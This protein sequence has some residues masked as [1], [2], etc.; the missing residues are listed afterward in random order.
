MFCRTKEA[1][2]LLLSF[3]RLGNCQRIDPLLAQDRHFSDDSSIYRSYLDF[4]ESQPW[5]SQ[6]EKI[7]NFQYWPWSLAS[8]P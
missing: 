3:K 6:N 4:R 7:S 8:L 5:C 1:Q 2:N